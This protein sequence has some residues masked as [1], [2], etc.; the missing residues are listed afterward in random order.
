ML[1]G[2]SALGVPFT[3]KCHLWRHVVFGSFM[4]S[5][6]GSRLDWL[7]MMMMMRM[8]MAVYV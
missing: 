2:M 3:P 4:C 6:D 5:T 1:Q 8:M 7:S